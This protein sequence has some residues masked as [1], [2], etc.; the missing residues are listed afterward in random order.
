[1]HVVG[2]AF[3]NLLQCCMVLTLQINCASG[4]F[5]QSTSTNTPRALVVAIIHCNL[6]GLVHV[7]L[8]LPAIGTNTPLAFVQLALHVCWWYVV[9]VIIIYGIVYIH[10]QTWY[11]LYQ[12]KMT[13]SSRSRSVSVLVVTNSTD[14]I[15]FYTLLYMQLGQQ[16]VVLL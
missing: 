6:V 16:V 8:F 15:V 11:N 2:A 12:W 13:G 5:L 3:Y 14:R 9:V 4:A 1:M 7:A 10:V